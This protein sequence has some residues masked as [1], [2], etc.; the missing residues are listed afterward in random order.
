LEGNTVILLDTQ[1]L[2]W[3][4]VDP[5]RLSRAASS[6]IRRARLADGIAISAITLWELSMLFSRDRIESYGTVESSVATVVES[7]SV[8][9]KPLTIAIAAMAAQFPENFPR[10]PA[11]RIIAAT[12]RLEGLNLI[13]RDE[14]IRESPLLRTTW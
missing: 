14:R 4:V 1:V 2:V 11:D 12:A 8:A 6:A 9:I 7:A 10:D 13:T 3:L 5:D